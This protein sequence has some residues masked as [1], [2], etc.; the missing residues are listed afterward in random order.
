MA[1]FG[2]FSLFAQSEKRN[3][4]APDYTGTLE[5]SASDIG[6]LV[7]HLS[8]AEQEDD[9]QGNPIVKLSLSAW[10]N[11]SKAGKKYLKGIFSEPYRPDGETAAKV[12]PISDNMPF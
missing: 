1:N 9:Y 7:R 5:V 12:D 4:K 3:E 8:N 2:K 10:I 6:E 11:E